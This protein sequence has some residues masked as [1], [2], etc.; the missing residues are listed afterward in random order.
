MC[1]RMHQHEHKISDTLKSSLAHVQD[2][3][4]IVVVIRV[5]VGV[6]D[7]F[8]VGRNLVGQEQSHRIMVTAGGDEFDDKAAKLVYDK[9]A[10]V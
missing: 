6:P 4:Q 2:T 7:Q 10:C 5:A 3:I 8:G 9:V 1:Q